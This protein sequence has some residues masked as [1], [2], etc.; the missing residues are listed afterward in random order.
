MEF[1]QVPSRFMSITVTKHKLWLLEF[2]LLSR[3]QT[4]LL[5]PG[6]TARRSLHF[7]GEGGSAI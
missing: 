7:L 3:A 2:H 4:S 6:F 1:F 5:A